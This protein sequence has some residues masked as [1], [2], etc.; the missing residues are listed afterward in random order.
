MLVCNYID[1]ILKSII[2]KLYLC[3]LFLLKIKIWFHLANKS[4]FYDTNSGVPF[5]L[6]RSKVDLFCQCPRCF[7]L[8]RKM[9]ISQPAGA[10]F[11]L[12][13]AVDVLLKKEFDGY[14]ERAEIHPFLKLNGVEAVPLS[15]PEIENWRNNRVGIQYLHVPTNFL[16][17]GA[18]DDIWQL[19]SGELVVVD[20]K[21]KATS[22]EITLEPKRKKNGEIVKTDSYL[23]GYQ[24]QIEFYQWLFRKNGFEVSSTAYFLFANAQKDRPSFDDHLDFEKVLIAY[25]GDDSWVEPTLLDIRKCLEANEF[26]KC[27]DTCDF[28]KYRAAVRRHLKEVEKEE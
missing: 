7:Y 1:F 21:A 16:L 8:D 27:N 10:P 3:I 4:N 17:Y 12:N 11:T 20:Y 28:C 13:I 26:P 6:S 2:N 15:H 9:G 18:I 22:N 14:R 23:I 5:R 24:R 19:S 25:K